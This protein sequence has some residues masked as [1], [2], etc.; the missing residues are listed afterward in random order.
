MVYRVRALPK[1]RRRHASCRIPPLASREP[2]SRPSADRLRPR[3][4]E[5]YRIYDGRHRFLAYVLDSR[6]SPVG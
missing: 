4:N 5:T 6:M 1:R 3:S 2:G